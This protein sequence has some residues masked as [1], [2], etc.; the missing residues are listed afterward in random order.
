MVI[1]PP[2]EPIFTIRP[3]AARINGRKDCVTARC[4]NTLT[5]NWRLNSSSGTYSSGQASPMPLLFTS[6]A[7]PSSPTASS[8]VVAAAATRCSSVTSMNSG[9]RRPTGA[10]SSSAPASSSFLTP[11]KTRNPERANFIA[12][13]RPIPL[14]APVTTTALGRRPMCAEG[15]RDLLQIMPFSFECFVC[16]AMQQPVYDASTVQG[17]LALPSPACRRGLHCLENRVELAQCRSRLCYAALGEE[18]HDVA[19]LLRARPALVGQANV[20][21]VRV[22]QGLLGDVGRQREIRP[23]PRTQPRHRPRPFCPGRDEVGQPLIRRVE[24]F[25]RTQLLVRCPRRPIDARLGRRV[26]DIDTELGR[27][28][29]EAPKGVGGG[30]VACVRTDE[31]HHAEDIGERHALRERGLDVEPERQAKVLPANVV[32]QVEQELLPGART[33]ETV[34]QFPGLKGYLLELGIYVPERLA[35]QVNHGN[36]LSLHRLDDRDTGHEPSTHNRP[37]TAA[38]PQQASGSHQ[39]CPTERTSAPPVP[40][41]GGRP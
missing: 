4:P 8:T 13:A 34:G 21:S 22:A 40:L 20:D 23:L 15:T 29:T 41:S 5:S 24:P 27:D 26:T 18:P 14:E 1:R 9:V 36:F 30:R 32:S 10:A 6:P 38:L 17:T 7:I 31:T 2:T 33:R 12:E 19:D 16:V 11:A 3:V 25:V 37:F 35:G 28:C 39:R